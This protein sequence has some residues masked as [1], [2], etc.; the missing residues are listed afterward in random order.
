[1]TY[2]MIKKDEVQVLLMINYTKHLNKKTLFL[3]YLQKLKIILI[4]K[5]HLLY[6]QQILL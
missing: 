2:K 5:T 4:K 6:Q 1:M 3:L